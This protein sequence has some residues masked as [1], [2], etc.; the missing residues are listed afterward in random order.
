MARY[1]KQEQ[2]LVEGATMTSKTEEVQRHRKAVCENTT[3]QWPSE[4][5]VLSHPIATS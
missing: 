2:A 1:K 5:S 4:R 3:S